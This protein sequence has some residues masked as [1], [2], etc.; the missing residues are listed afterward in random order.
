MTP[1][2]SVGGAALPAQSLHAVSQSNPP[3]GYTT[4]SPALFLID[5]NIHACRD[6]AARAL[7]HIHP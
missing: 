1:A 2:A 7:G 3:N 4:P 5:V 6:A